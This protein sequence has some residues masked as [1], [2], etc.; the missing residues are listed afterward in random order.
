MKKLFIPA[1][2]T[3]FLALPG[4]A[5]KINSS[6]VPAAVKAAFAKEYPGTIAKWEKEKDNYE[7][8]FKKNG[9][10]MS[11]LIEPNGSIIETEMDIRINELPAKILTYVKKHYAGMSIKEASKITRAD[12]SVN[13]EASINGK[14]VLFDDNGKFIKET[15]D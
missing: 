6:K 11:L 3:A 8:S 5:Q 7:V 13:Y 2:V 15:K 14:E 1:V 4:L 12:R 9:T 10:K